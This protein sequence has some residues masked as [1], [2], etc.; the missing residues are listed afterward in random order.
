MLTDGTKGTD[1][2]I[3]FGKQFIA[4]HP[5][6]YVVLNQYENQANIDSHYYGTGAEII[7]DMPT[8]THFVAGMGTGGTLMGV[9]KRLKEYNETIEV[10]GIEP[11]KGSIIQGLRNM[12]AYVP[13]I[14]QSCMLDD[15]MLMTE[16]EPALLYAREI[17]KREGLSVGISSGAALWGA[18]EI[19]KRIDKGIIVT[20]FPDRGERYLT[21]KLVAKE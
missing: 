6:E 13:P 18:L 16:D 17:F 8:I 9:G 20:I 1:G 4:E 3:A 2:A 10:I 19:Q 15:V 5:G 12:G 14:Y 21:T 7:K 11:K